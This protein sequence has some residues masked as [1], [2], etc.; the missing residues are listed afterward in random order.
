MVRFSFRKGLRFLRATKGFTLLRR[1]PNGNFQ[2]EDDSGDISS[3]TEA[4]MH[5]RWR[6]GEWQIDE[7]SLAEFSNVFYFTTPKD[8]KALPE[9]E[10]NEA[11]R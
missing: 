2:L 5:R 3:V 10:Q 11:K 7:E 6:T 8:L 1:I 9:A 4:E